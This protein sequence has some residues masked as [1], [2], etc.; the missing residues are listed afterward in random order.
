L[1]FVVDEPDVALVPLVTL[2]VGAGAEVVFV[3]GAVSPTYTVALASFVPPCP[4]QESVKVVVCESVGV[5]T[6]PDAPPVRSVVLPCFTVHSFARNDVQERREVVPTAIDDGLATNATDGAG[7]D[8][9]GGGGATVI[10]G[11]DAYG[12]RLGCG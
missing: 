7:V 8:C 11:C 3:L 12:C 1:L 10:G 5:M 4:V 6:E 2:R 9:P